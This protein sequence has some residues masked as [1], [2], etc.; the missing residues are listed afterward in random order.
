MSFMTGIVATC[1][2]GVQRNRERWTGFYDWRTRRTSTA[3]FRVSTTAP[4]DSTD[5]RTWLRPLVTPCCRRPSGDN[6]PR[7]ALS[8]GSF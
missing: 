8:E 5:F 6:E 1:Q 4:T 3:L 7:G 2:P